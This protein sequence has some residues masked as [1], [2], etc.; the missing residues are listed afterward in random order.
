MYLKT[1]SIRNFRCFGEKK[2]D[3]EFKRG[4][5]V[6]IGENN[7]GKTTLFDALRLAFNCGIGRR[8]IYVSPDDFH[9]GDTAQRANTISFDLFFE[10]FLIN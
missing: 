4:V 5:N 9:I 10:V 3:F 8:D 6:I 7:A 1:F 2:V